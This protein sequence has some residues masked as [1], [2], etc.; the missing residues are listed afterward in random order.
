LPYYVSGYSSAY[1]FIELS[2][3][4]KSMRMSS[5]M[6]VMIAVAGVTASGCMS[7]SSDPLPRRSVYVRGTVQSLT[8]LML[9]VVTVTGPVSVMLVPPSQVSLVVASDRGHLKDGIY[10]GITSVKQPDGS[11]R[12]LEVHI[13]PPGVPRT[14]EGSYTW[15]LSTLDAGG[16]AM[17]NGTTSHALARPAEADPG[18]PGLKDVDATG[19]KAFRGKHDEGTSLT[20]Q[21]K[22]AGSARLQSLTIP[23]GVPIVRFENGLAL[24]LTPGAHVLVIAFRTPEGELSVNRVLVGKNGLVPS[25]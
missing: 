6:I 14:G 12:A 10:M 9:T 23:W 17:T 2:E 4:R 3:V 21:F 18:L 24:D 8:G 15:D 19:R 1:F 5:G 22:S 11:L 25:M 16:A 13:F 20:L 7:A